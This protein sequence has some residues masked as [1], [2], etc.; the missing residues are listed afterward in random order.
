VLGRVNWWA[1]GPLV[2]LLQRFGT[3]EAHGP[4]ETS[5]QEIR[6]ADEA[7]VDTPISATECAQIPV[8]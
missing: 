2:R 6:T 7:A 8:A 4:Q 3:I 5:W 1:P